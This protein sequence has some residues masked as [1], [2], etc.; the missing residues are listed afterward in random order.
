MY[1]DSLC[2]FKRNT[3]GKEV[4]VITASYNVISNTAE[5][6]TRVFTH[7]KIFGVKLISYYDRIVIRL[8]GKRNI[9]CRLGIKK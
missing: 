2:V 3:V 8:I 6:K 7:K 4:S 1:K 5:H 9:K